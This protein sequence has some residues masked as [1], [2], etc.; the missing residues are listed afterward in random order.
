[1]D[2]LIKS[3]N[4]PYYLDRCLFSIQKHVVNNGNVV[5]LDDGTPQIYLDK[6]QEKYPFVIIKKSEFYNE[7]VTYTS[8]GKR[9]E[10]YKIPIEFWLNAAKNASEN[11]I[12]IEDDTW[13]IDD[14]NLNE[15]N[16]EIANNSVAMT[17]L[18]WIGNS[19]INQN[20]K[21]QKLNNIVLLEPKLFTIVPSIYNFIFYKFDKFKIRKTLRLFKIHTDEKHLAYY[22][23]YAV[24]GMI[25]NKE[26]FLSLWKN[27]QNKVD[28]GLQ[29]YNAVKKFKDSKGKLKFAR[30]EKEVLKTGFI[31]SATNEHKEKFSGNVDMFQ[32]NKIMNEAWLNDTFEVIKS[33]PNDIHS[34]EVVKVL[35]SSNQNAIQTENWINWSNDFKN[36]Y[37]NIGCKID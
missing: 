21:E 8:V 14:V 12:L 23:I 6:I 35:N 30:C 34:D 37:I 5:V 28:E 29:L 10:K 20:K 15:I 13:F 16:N 11:F 22:T 19:I 24:A 3:Y 27:H 32:F 18:Y 25:F 26:Y 9:P 7:K 31:S 33:L 1:M 4:R 17:K 2:I 36:Y